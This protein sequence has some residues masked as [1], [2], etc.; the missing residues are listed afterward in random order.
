MRIER[1]YTKKGQDAYA[2]IEFRTTKS[3]I[4]NPD[5]SIVFKLDDID[6][7]A[8]WSQVASDILAQKYF[9]K[10]GVPAA[11]KRVEEYDV[12]SFLWRSAADSVRAGQA[13]PTASATSPNAIRARSSTAWPAPGPIGAGRAA[14]STPRRTPRPSTTSTATCSPP[15]RRRRTHRNGSTPA[16]TGPTASTARAR[17]TTTSTSHRPRPRLAK[18][19]RAPAAACLLH[20]V[21]RRR[22]RQR[23]RHHG[24]VGA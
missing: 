19:L 24:P 8:S 15:R 9:R 14:T 21:G 11:L 3:E 23:G 17:V 22:P 20:P 18:R 1:R 6:V 12:P 10:A 13:A 5:G 2:G 7:P 16:S 4:R